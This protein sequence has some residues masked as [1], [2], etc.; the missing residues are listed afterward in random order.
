MSIAIDKR[1]IG[2]IFNPL[3]YKE[4]I[5]PSDIKNRFKLT[6]DK[7][8][9]SSNKK[10]IIYTNK[11]FVLRVYNDRN[12]QFS[13]KQLENPIENIKKL[14]K[15][16]LCKVI[17]QKFDNDTVFIFPYQVEQTKEML[18]KFNYINLIIPLT[19]YE[20]NHKTEWYTTN[21]SSYQLITN[22]II[23]YQKTA[24]GNTVLIKIINTLLILRLDKDLLNRNETILLFL[25]RDD[26]TYKVIIP[27]EV[28]K[29]HLQSIM[30][31]D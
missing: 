22:S 5:V 26:E 17:T 12:K 10:F 13:K 30:L 20:V 1:L 15:T 4:I 23:K 31:S 25:E 19:L 2:V 7:V 27:I 11:K 24:S 16:R 18:N 21:I 8:F 9:I 29:N 3:W 28:I 6:F 14:L